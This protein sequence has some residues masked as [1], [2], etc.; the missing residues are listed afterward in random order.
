MGTLTSKSSLMIN[1]RGVTPCNS[2]SD[3]RFVCVCVWVCM[4]LG[5]HKPISVAACI[6]EDQSVC[7]QV[8]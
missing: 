4:C 7:Q 6:S 2:V 3:S 1:I 8:S 5:A